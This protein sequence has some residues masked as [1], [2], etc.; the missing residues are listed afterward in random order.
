MMALA[1]PGS[2]SSMHMPLVQT[3]NP[4]SQNSMTTITERRGS[5]VVLQTKRKHDGGK[6]RDPQTNSIGS[7]KS[8][9]TKRRGSVLQTKRR[10]DGG[11]GRDPQ[12]NSVGL[13]KSTENGPK[14]NSVGL[15]ETTTNNRSS[16]N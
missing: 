9:T 14:T 10:H 11:K 4:S 3:S 2:P 7:L 16:E 5:V 13:L 8:T 6:G 1:T 12:T 15:L